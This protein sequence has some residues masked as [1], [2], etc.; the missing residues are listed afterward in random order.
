MGSEED[1]IKSKQASKKVRTLFFFASFQFHPVIPGVL[2]A[3]AVLVIL[4]VQDSE[5][6][7]EVL[8]HITARAM[9]AAMFI[10]KPMVYTMAI[11]KV[12]VS[13]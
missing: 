13:H 3:P 2:A 1:E 4:V 12:P 8:V 5:K 6:L 11:L 10:L 9:V 7:M